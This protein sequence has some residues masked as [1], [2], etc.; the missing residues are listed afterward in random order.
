MIMT[1]MNRQGVIRKGEHECFKRTLAFFFL[2][3]DNVE[4]FAIAVLLIKQFHEDSRI[5][6]LKTASENHLV[7][8]WNGRRAKNLRC[9]NIII[10]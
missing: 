4:E 9:Y 6:S 5:V 10:Q 3:I 7:R 1:L 8:E 2:R